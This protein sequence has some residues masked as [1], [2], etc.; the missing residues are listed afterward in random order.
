LLSTLL[1]LDLMLRSLNDLRG[2]TASEGSFKN[3]VGEPIL[4]FIT[5]TR[6]RGAPPRIEPQPSYGVSARGRPRLRSAGGLGLAHA[7]SDN[8]VVAGHLAVGPRE[9]IA[10]GAPASEAAFIDGGHNGRT[11]QRSLVVFSF[12]AMRFPRAPRRRSVRVLSISPAWSF[13]SER[14]AGRPGI[15]LAASALS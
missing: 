4:F 7:G 9:E 15:Y 3:W 2:H 1:Q 13:L 14:K 5:L 6:A 11:S 12:F 10:V 8:S